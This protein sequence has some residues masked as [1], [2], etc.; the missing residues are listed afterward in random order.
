MQEK[1]RAFVYYG[2]ENYIALSLLRMMVPG[3]YLFMCFFAFVAGIAGN[4]LPLAFVFLAVVATYAIIVYTFH[5]WCPEPSFACRFAMSAFSSLSLGAIFQLWMYTILFAAKQIDVFDLIVF[6]ALQV[7]AAVIYACITGSRIKKGKFLGK[8]SYKTN[9]A[10]GAIV[11]ASY[12]GVH[13]GRRLREVNASLAATLAM[14]CFTFLAVLCTVV[15][16]LHLMKYY[17]C[18]KY[19]IDRGQDGKMTSPMLR[20]E[21]KPKK[22]LPRRIWSIV[23]KSLVLLLLVAILFG[24]H[25]ASQAPPA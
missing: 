8:R 13:F 15:G 9:I 12:G 17:Y 16:T 18:K 5:I 25:Q 20:A 14:V 4:A 3:A 24:V 19:S 7:A 1:I 2:S 6:F 11:S 10:F 23:W 21:K 22:S